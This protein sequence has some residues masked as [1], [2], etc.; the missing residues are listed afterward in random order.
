MPDAVNTQNFEKYSESILDYSFDWSDW[1]DYDTHEIIQTYDFEI[2]GPDTN[3][4]EV[5]R[6]ISSDRKMITIWVTG[7]TPKARYKIIGKITTNSTPINRHDIRFIR[8]LI[9]PED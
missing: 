5:N 6:D 3:L 9:L 4:T 1:L 7:G 8:L 2:V